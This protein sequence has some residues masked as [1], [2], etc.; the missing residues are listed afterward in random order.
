VAFDAIFRGEG[1]QDR[2]QWLDR[3]KRSAPENSLPNYIS[4]L[5]Y[6]KAGQ[7]DAAVRELQTAQ[8]K[9]NF[10]DYS[11]DF[12]QDG[13]EA[14]RAAGY[15]EAEA[16]MAAVTQ[17]L[18]PHLAPLK[19]LGNQLIGLAGSYR[20]AGDEASAQQTLQIAMNLGQQLAEPGGGNFLIN[21]LVG[22]AMEKMIF[23]SLDPNS[24]YGSSGRTVKD[25]L[26]EIQLKRDAIKQL[27]REEEKF[28]KTMS[29]QDIALYFERLKIFGGAEAIEWLKRR[30]GQ[31]L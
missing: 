23:N 7:T 15:S 5:D 12:L 17:L 21:N 6:L 3:F 30:A 25:Y 4:A 8:G 11:L 22:L 26:E 18:L 16:K 2:R 9:A 28:L 27:A 20:Q 29:E 19:D 1:D 13:E 14:Y 10:Q 31:G 24:E